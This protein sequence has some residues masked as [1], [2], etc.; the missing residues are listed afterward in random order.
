MDDSYAWRD[1]NEPPNARRVSSASDDQ[2]IG[3]H[4][5][6]EQLLSRE[7]A[8][9]ERGTRRTSMGT[10]RKVVKKPFLKKG[11]RGW[12]M[13]NPE[14]K[15]KMHRHVLISTEETETTRT[16][17][18]RRST[19]PMR[20][21]AS[22]SPSS[23]S[24]H[25]P[26]YTSPAVSQIASRREQ[27]ADISPVRRDPPPATAD[28]R[29]SLPTWARHGPLPTNVSVETLNMSGVRRDY[30]AKLEKDAD[31]LADFEA[32]EQELAKEKA[33]YLQEK[34]YDREF[35]SKTTYD[36]YDDDMAWARASRSSQAHTYPLS[37][38]RDTQPL[39]QYPLPPPSTDSFDLGGDSSL[40][41]ESEDHFFGPPMRS[42]SRQRPIARPSIVPSELSAISYNDSEPWAES[43]VADHFSRVP[44]SPIP[45]RGMTSV[46]LNPARNG[47][48]PSPSASHQDL[49]W[50]G[51]GSDLAW[52][53]EDHFSE[54]LEQY[55]NNDDTPHEE[56]R[57]SM[58][59]YEKPPVSNLV[60]QVFGAGG[61]SDSGRSED[62]NRT[63]EESPRESTASRLPQQ[64][65]GVVSNRKTPPRPRPVRQRGAL[66]PRSSHTESAEASGR[67]T[68][69]FDSNGT[70]P[71]AIEEKL[72][73]LEE[74]VKFYKAE[75]LQLQKKK[76]HYEDELRKFAKEKE[77]FNKFQ[78][79]QRQLIQQEWE[80][81]RQK[82]KREEKMFERQM[83]LKLNAAS[84]TQSRKDRGEIDALKAQIVKLQLEAKQ[85]AGKS[86]STT[87][88]LRQ[89]IT[90]LEG[91]NRELSEEIKFLEKDRLEQ[92]ERYEQTVKE[93]EKQKTI[94]ETKANTLQ[95]VQDVSSVAR[96][97][98]A[99][100][101]SWKSKEEQN[102][103][104]PPRR[105]SIGAKSEG[106]NPTRYQ[107]SSSSASDST[108]KETEAF[109]QH[110]GDYWSE[111]PPREHQSPSR[112]PLNTESADGNVV[113]EVV[114]PGG[115]REL[116]YRN[117][118]KKIF[119]AD[120]NEK[121]IQA[122][123]HVIIRF[124][125]GDR[126]EYFPETGISVYHYAE[127]QT[128][129]TTYPD[130]TKI[131]EF[132]NQQ[133]EK[134]FPDGTT[135]ILFADGIKKIIRANGDEFSTFPDGTTMLETGEG[136]REV[137]LL[138]QTKVRYYP[139]GRMAL[140]SVDGRETLVRSDAELKRLMESG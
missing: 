128:K 116:T 13:E 77:D 131:Y 1:Q 94:N 82:M 87:D 48:Q 71:V 85:S 68:P 12:W 19:P 109:Q 74:E 84:S 6:F 38:I 122:D 44:E 112:D 31:E 43:A 103:S 22:P 9:E 67:P 64:K 23:S 98:E 30:E 95:T 79:Q 127:A 120:G 35:E 33:S 135:E 8:K 3:T 133:T 28:V 76:T 55:D 57:Q 105:V 124:T 2:Q 21:K 27:P 37:S 83:K 100:L 5:S 111:T 96:T 90:E 45:K 42:N 81:E 32:L 137:T 61:G 17:P 62:T 119:F 11:S 92:W 63:Y 49:L 29:R 7:L 110:P 136:L 86:K 69:R 115:K 107:R 40:V 139:D 39:Q 52:E 121:E 132:P 123:G 26:Q 51:K 138:N 70:L 58:E 65:T 88:A 10:G 72:A 53:D 91:R 14:A 25:S 89:R 140:V 75:T 117:G 34:Q 97:A 114:H 36:E 47:R 18:R 59:Q 16:P 46:L 125:N 126:K 99:F 130:K 41:F 104:T 113:N 108:S 134:S 54:S 66:S 20:R 78:E 80:R 56:R 50:A 60:R 101:S 102:P 73:E 15:H 129:L 118:T 93:L 106:Y 24:E 4:A